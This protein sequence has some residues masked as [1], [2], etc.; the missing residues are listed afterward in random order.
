MLHL[1]KRPDHFPFLFRDVL[2]AV[3]TFWLL[4]R[5]IEPCY[6]YWDEHRGQGLEESA[7]PLLGQE[8]RPAR[9]SLLKRE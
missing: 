2:A 5:L 8:G 7:K 6:E 3:S 9:A 1:P 4:P